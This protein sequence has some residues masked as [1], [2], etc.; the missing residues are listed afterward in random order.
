MERIL[1]APN[2]I[3][4]EKSQ[5]VKK[6]TGEILEIIDQLKKTLVA[7]K[8]PK[9]VGLA[10]PQI[11]KSFRI[12][13]IKTYQKSPFLVFINPEIVWSSSK[14]TKK[15]VPRRGNK[16]NRF[17]GCLSIP[18]IWGLVHRPEKI[19]LRYQT[20]DPKL[21]T[22]DLPRRQAGQRLTTKSRTFSGFLATIIQHEIDHL[23]GTLFT[24]RVLEQKEK[25]Y[26]LTKDKEGK[27][28]FEPISI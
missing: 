28:T 19:K 24:Q 10:A 23:N 25:L 22:N 6:V 2:S 5:P 21:K 18:N 16:F 27:E 20:L 15:G 13:V 11:G 3:L 26:K 7:T 8:N 14:K 12:F 9:G 4:S 17:E 1:K